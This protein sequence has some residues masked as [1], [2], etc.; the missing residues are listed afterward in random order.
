MLMSE[1]PNE[2]GFPVRLTPEERLTRRR[3]RSHAAL[4]K[5]ALEGG[6]D[7][8]VDVPIDTGLWSTAGLSDGATEMLVSLVNERE[9]KRPK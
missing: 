9:Q 2:S 5:R 8:I 6:G 7:V 1:L 3:Y 4:A